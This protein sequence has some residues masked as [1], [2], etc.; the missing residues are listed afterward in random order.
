MILF[1]PDLDELRERAKA[2]AMTHFVRMGDADG[3]PAT[4]RAMYVRKAE[5]AQLVLDGGSS[6][7][8]EGEAALRGITPQQMA[9][10]IV[11]MAAAGGDEV[12]LK[13][14]ATNIAIESAATEVEIMEV[15]RTRGIPMQIDM[16]V[17]GSTAAAGEA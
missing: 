10:V 8:I 3:V 4:L 1:G 15:L 17:S 6:P 5:Q 2:A 7:L 11:S 12:E 16:S 13:R 14:M 9:Q